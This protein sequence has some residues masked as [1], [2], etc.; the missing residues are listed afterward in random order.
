MTPKFLLCNPSFYGIQYNINFWMPSNIG[1]VN[2]DLAYEQWTNL[3]I[4]LNNISKELYG[5]YSIVDIFPQSGL[6]DMVFTANAGLVLDKTIVL[7]NFR[8]PERQPEKEIFKQWFKNKGYSIL[9]LPSSIFFEGEGDA[10]F[11]SHNRLWVGHGFRSDEV[12]AYFLS[13]LHSGVHTL[14]LIDPRFYHLDTCFA[15]LSKGHVMYYPPAFDKISLNK[16]EV[17]FGYYT[18]RLIPVTEED[19]LNFSCNAINVGDYIVVNNISTILK[20][21]LEYFGYTVIV[22]SVSEFLKA[23]GGTACLKLKI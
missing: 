22:I 17:E 20:E 19:A 23:G 6:P 18:N 7:S 3:Y 10:L 13:D 21:H 5:Y 1:K 11:D 2:Y 16:I 12:A 15:P 8:C 14:K 9:E 4:T